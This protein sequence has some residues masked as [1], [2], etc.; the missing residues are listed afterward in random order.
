LFEPAVVLLS[1]PRTSSDIS[2]RRD[3]SNVGPLRPFR[4]GFGRRRL[5]GCGDRSTGKSVDE[6]HP[7]PRRRSAP[8]RHR[9]IL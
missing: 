6:A 5:T 8:V 2:E 7:G 9:L 3:P 1:C 4:R